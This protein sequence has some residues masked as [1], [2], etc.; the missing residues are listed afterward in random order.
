LGGDLLQR[1]AR[2]RL[3]AGDQTDQPVVALLWLGAVQQAGLDEAFVGQKPHRAA[4]LFDRTDGPRFW[5][6]TRTNVAPGLVRAHPPH[7]R[8]PR[9]QLRQDTVEMR[10]ITTGANLADGAGSPARRP[11]LP[12]MRPR[13]RAACRPAF[14]RSAIRA[15]SSWATA[16]STWSE[17]TPCGV[18]V[19]IGSRRLRKCAPLASSCSEVADGLQAV[20]GEG[21]G[22]GRFSPGRPFAGG[23]IAI[24]GFLS[25]S[26]GELIAI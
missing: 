12:P 19:S 11:G 20:P 17:N 26:S 25:R 22:R 3:D 7:G 4:Q 6:R 21:W 9:V 24:L 15:R 13:L 14:V 1:F 2:C 18:V 16:P 23:R 8:Q 5:F 10:G